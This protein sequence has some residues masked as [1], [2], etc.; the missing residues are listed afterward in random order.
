MHT[1]LAKIKEHNPCTSG[2]KRLLS[3]LGKSSDDDAPLSLLTI[4]E[5]NGLEDTLWA[6]RAVDGYDKQLRLFSVFCA[7]QNQ[8][9]LTD[10]RSINAIDTAEQH[11]N[12][13]ATAEELSAAYAAAGAAGAAADAAAA[14]AARAADAAADAASA[15]T[16]AAADAARAAAYAAGAAAGAAAYAAA[17]AAADAARAAARAAA[18][19]AAR[20]AYAAYA[21]ARAAA[22]AAQ[23]KELIH[24]FGAN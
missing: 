17:G 5:S 11:A 15:A 12:G 19:A 4:L 14:D 8:H 22:D 10:A 6:L 2:W 20:A 16:Y 9:M 24:L 18:G 1:T 23:E 13:Q 3:Y 21:A 7:R